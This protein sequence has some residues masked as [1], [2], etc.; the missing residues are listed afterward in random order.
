MNAL[1]LISLDN[2]IEMMVVVADEAQRSIG[3]S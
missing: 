1:L 3:R 2:V